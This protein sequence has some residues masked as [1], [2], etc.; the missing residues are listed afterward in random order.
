MSLNTKLLDVGLFD[1]MV[2]MNS[3][4]KD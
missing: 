2:E 4:A 1:T 3:P